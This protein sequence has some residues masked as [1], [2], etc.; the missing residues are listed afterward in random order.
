MQIIDNLLP[1]RYEEHL[2][3]L[4]LGE[5][6]PWFLN[7]WTVQPGYLKKVPEIDKNIIDV[8]QFTHRF[9][10]YGDT[11][12][13]LQSELFPLLILLEKETGN[14]YVDRLLRVK[15]NLITKQPNFPDNYYNPAHVDDHDSNETLLYYVNDSDGDTILF[16]E[17]HGSDSLTIKETCSPKRGRCILFDSSFLHSSTPPRN[18][19]F[20]A[21]INFVFKRKD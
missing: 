9:F 2:E 20:R 3:K 7:Q 19:E 1:K 11:I 10:L 12:S 4:L 14:S 18:T 8:P 21:V 13:P 17:K 15:A 16:N 5:Q 6:F